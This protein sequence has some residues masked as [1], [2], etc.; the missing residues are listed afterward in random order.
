MDAARDLL[1]RAGR[2]DA[3]AFAELFDPHR[4]PLRRAVAWRMDRRLAARIDVSDVLQETA[5]EAARRLPDYAQNP[6]M[7]FGLWLRW[8]AREKLLQLER[9]HFAEKRT[10]SREAPALPV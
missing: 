3:A 8:L 7:P 5:M 2:G 10:V 1:E 9:V 6:A 4:E